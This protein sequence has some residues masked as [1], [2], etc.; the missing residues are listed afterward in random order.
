M[1]NL[2]HAPTK[3]P[4]FIALVAVSAI[5]LVVTYFAATG[6]ITLRQPDEHG[7]TP[8]AAKELSPSEAAKTADNC[9]IRTTDRMLA[10]TDPAQRVAAM[11]LAACRAELDQWRLALARSY[12]EQIADAALVGAGKDQTA[13]VIRKI[14][15]ARSRK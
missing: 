13:F 7:T 10:S 15:E 12:G 14:T 3:P 8:A 11:V 4:V 9:V 6:G 1:P 5:V 2:S